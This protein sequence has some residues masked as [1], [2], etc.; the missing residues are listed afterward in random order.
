M[1]GIDIT[2]THL[3]AICETVDA[4][5]ESTSIDHASLES[6]LLRICGLN[7]PS[8]LSEDDEKI[9]QYFVDHLGSWTGTLQSLIDQSV[10]Y[11][12]CYDDEFEAFEKAAWAL[13]LGNSSTACYNRMRDHLILIALTQR[14]CCLSIYHYTDRN[15]LPDNA[16]LV[17]NAFASAAAVSIASFNV[18]TAYEASNYI[19][20]RSARLAD[21]RGKSVELHFMAMDLAHK[22]FMRRPNP[23]YAKYA[24]QNALAIADLQGSE[25][26]RMLALMWYLEGYCC[27]HFRKIADHS[28]WLLD[29]CKG[30]V[31]FSGGV[32]TEWRDIPSLREQPNY[33]SEYASRIQAELG[34]YQGLTLDLLAGS[35]L[36]RQLSKL[37]NEESLASY[38]FLV[39]SEVAPQDYTIQTNRFAMNPMFWIWRMLETIA[40]RGFTPDGAGQTL[41]DVATCPGWGAPS[42]EECQAVDRIFSMFAS[43]LWEN[44]DMVPRVA[45]PNC[46]LQIYGIAPNVAE[47]SLGAEWKEII[48]GYARN[49]YQGESLEQIQTK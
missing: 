14:L 21:N 8:E 23:R 32:M 45:L 2:A 11:T 37:P 48:L 5:N 19:F 40:E 28:A 39:S 25:R 43:I 9:A 26:L 24:A 44:D 31:N 3:L 15:L 47:I 38:P 4:D 7:P 46:A 27:F 20:N 33:F 18:A 34:M 29:Y 41:G 35:V 49:V 12:V 36:F 13:P 10:P 30:W 6:I 22:A 1:N 42:P 16:Q 17:L